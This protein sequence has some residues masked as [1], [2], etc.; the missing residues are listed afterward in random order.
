MHELLTA[1]LAGRLPASGAGDGRRWRGV[2]EGILELLPD[3]GGP[4]G[5]RCV[6][7]SAGIHGDE[8]APAEV[9][10]ALVRD[11]QQAR[12]PLAVRLLVVLGNPAALRAG[13]RYVDEDLNRLFAGRRA[14]RTDTVEAARAA[15]IERAM[16]DFLASA[17][18]AETTLHLDLHTAIRGSYFERFGL[19]PW[20]PDARY[21]PR[22][23]DWLTRCELEAVLINHA[24]A[25]T[26]A[27][28]SSDAF[29]AASCTLE[30]G[31]VRPFGQ[32]DLTRFTATDRALRA[33]VSGVPPAAPSR[34]PRVFRVVGE[35]EKKSEAFDLLV[36]D[37]V[38]NFTA[39]P[40][41]TVIAR[42][43]AYRYVVAHD[44]E[45]IV[46][47][48]RTVRPGLRAGLMVVEESAASLWP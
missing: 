9:L 15:R 29:G 45:R 2:A 19:L 39:F 40:R 25:G 1:T 32:N 5:S 36:A 42:D 41:G 26:F 8:T 11:V 33:L 27:F 47:P 10:D 18:R 44:E 4:G 7:L 13:E 12:L 28:H 20:R 21:D 3:R 35:L 31:E 37:D 34:R 14:G 23:L 24:P 30:L 22:L 46:F 48:N 6:V 16:A 43:G 17:D 38:E